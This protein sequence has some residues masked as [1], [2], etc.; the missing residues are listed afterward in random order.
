MLVGDLDEVALYVQCL[1][2][3]SDTYVVMTA[4]IHFI[5]LLLCCFKFNSRSLNFL[6]LCCFLNKSQW[7]TVLGCSKQWP[8]WLWV[9]TPI[10]TVLH[11]SGRNARQMFGSDELWPDSLHWAK[12]W[13][14]LWVMP[15]SFAKTVSNKDKENHVEQ[16][17][18]Q[19]RAVMKLDHC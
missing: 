5:F 15:T 13:F 4:C 3:F 18:C 14:K 6:L 10:S 7:C 9:S 2:S 1:A 17:P 11:T 16:N 12:T 8:C 19:V